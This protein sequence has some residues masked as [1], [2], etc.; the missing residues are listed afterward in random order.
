MSGEVL[1][2]AGFRV[3]GQWTR[4]SEGAINLDATVPLE[5]GIYAFV[6]NNVVAYVGLTNNSLRTRFDQYRLG[7]KAQRTNA[8][9]KKLIDKALSEGQQVM[10]L[11]ATPEPLQ[12]NGLPVNAAAGLEAGL[13]Q[14]I[15]P[16]WNIMGVV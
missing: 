8:R 9:V 12:W 15:R 14:M 4:E 2:H 5:P 11:V 3:V 7:H 6:V 10:I 1:M 13:I 16:A